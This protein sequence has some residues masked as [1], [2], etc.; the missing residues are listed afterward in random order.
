MISARAL[1]VPANS[2]AAVPV[3]I[4]HS[5]PSLLTLPSPS[6]EIRFDITAGASR[7]V[8]S[9][10]CG[11]IGLEF[12]DA[13]STGSPL[14]G[15]GSCAFIAALAKPPA[16]HCVRGRATQD[17]RRYMKSAALKFS[18]VKEP[19]ACDRPGSCRFSGEEDCW[20]A[21][22]SEPAASADDPRAESDPRPL[23]ARA[24]GGQN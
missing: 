15:L 2:R 10:I 16:A 19:G 13:A 20:T 18:N 8:M 22:W 3:T 9:V 24:A 11:L 5:D 14:G 12:G 17:R 23:Q 6:R 21:S 4:R 1:A 7:L